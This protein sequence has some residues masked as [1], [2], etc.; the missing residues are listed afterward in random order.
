M[1]QSEDYV[2]IPCVDVLTWAFDNE[3][4]DQG[5]PVSCALGLPSDQDSHRTRYG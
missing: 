3:D 1:F 4:Y 5:R 2:E